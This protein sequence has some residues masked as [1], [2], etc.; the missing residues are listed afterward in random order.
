MLQDISKLIG[1]YGGLIALISLLLAI[2]TDVGGWRRA[3]L[4]D[5]K[6]KIASPKGRAAL[7]TESQCTFSESYF[8]T[9]RKQLIWLWRIYGHPGSRKAFSRCLQFAY[10]YPFLF[11]LIGWVGWNITDPGGLELFHDVPNIWSRVGRAGLAI[12]SLVC[13][14]FIFKS[15][16]K[17]GDFVFDR[18]YKFTQRGGFLSKAPLWVFRAALVGA[19]AIAGAIAGAILVALVGAGAGVVALVGVGVGALAGVADGLP[20]Y[21]LFYLLLPFANAFADWLSLRFTRGF[22]KHTVQAHRSNHNP[23]ILRR[24]FFDLCLGTFCLAL[25][26]GSL[27]GLLELWAYLYI[28]SLPFYW[29]DYWRT[30][31]ETPSE[32]LMLW[33][34][35]FTTL[36]PTL[37]HVAWAGAFWWRQKSYYTQRA[38]RNMEV[39]TVHAGTIDPDDKA[40]DIKEIA[41][42]LMRGRRLGW[43]KAGLA[44]VA[45]CAAIGLA[46]WFA[47]QFFPL[48][49]A[50]S[51][52]ETPI[53][54]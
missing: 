5:L 21:G 18:L 52:I 30:A 20:L 15:S 43:A 11:A 39:L 28:P 31:I 44:T 22:L 50:H 10:I 34:M 47:L 17:I 6:I 4:D 25:L 46:G 2:V 13:L 16:N 12:L 8:R 38:A 32:G 48:P 14:A 26:L 9:T 41:K 42:D 27:V 51:P 36:F 7:I 33:L 54:T 53:S 45:I 37:T 29:Q 40:N 24:A 1:E 49:A 23:K 3:G 19:V 35:C